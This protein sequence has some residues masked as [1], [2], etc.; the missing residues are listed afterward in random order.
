[1]GEMAGM[2]DCRQRQLVSS[3]ELEPIAIVLY[4]EYC[5]REI[6]GLKTVPSSPETTQR[7]YPGRI[8]VT[9]NA[10]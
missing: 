1:V 8:A 6:T 9:N 5:G 10:S 3:V 2:S 4:R 7:M